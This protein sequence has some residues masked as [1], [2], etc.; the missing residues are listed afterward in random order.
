MRKGDV[1][2][3]SRT[4]ISPSRRMAVFER[5]NFKCQYCGRSAPEVALEIDHILPVSENGKNDLSNLLTICTECNLG[6][7]DLYSKSIEKHIVRREIQETDNEFKF[8]ITLCEEE[9][10]VLRRA[11]KFVSERRKHDGISIADLLHDI[12]SKELICIDKVLDWVEDC[13]K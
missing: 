12:I 4:K 11:C 5:D 9:Y 6:K 10:E 13:E 7:S 8:I 1:A 3:G 2:M